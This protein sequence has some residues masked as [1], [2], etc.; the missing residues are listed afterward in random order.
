MTADILQQYRQRNAP[1]SRAHE[2]TTFH[3]EAR[4]KL[5]YFILGAT[6]AICGYLAQTNPYGRLGLNKETF[7]LG[8]LLVFAASAVAG[9]KGIETN[10]KMIRMNADALETHDAGLRDF[11]LKKLGED[12][13]AHRCYIAKKYLLLAGFACYLATKVWA[14]YQSNGWIPVH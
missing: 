13:T 10:I 11:L 4:N 3:N 2:V 5:D 14:E 7:L 1:L 12:R 6:L 8:T 9:F